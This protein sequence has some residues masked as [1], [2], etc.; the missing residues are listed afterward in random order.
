MARARTVSKD[1]V[2]F[3]PDERIEDE[4]KLLLDEWAEKQSDPITVPVPIEDIIELHL[5]LEFSISDLKTELGH[6][7]VL[8]AIWFGDRRIK[9]DESLDFNQYPRMRGRYFFTLAHEVG[10]WRLHRQ[11]LAEDP[12]ALRLFDKDG[13]PAFVCRSTEKPREEWQA[14]TFASLVLMPKQLVRDAWCDWR[15][16]D[17]PVRIGDLPVCDF[18][19]KI[20]ADQNMAM[21]RF[22]KPMAERFEVSA[23]AMRIRLQKLGLMV[24][25]IEP[26]LF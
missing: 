8:G 13:E 12:N 17:D 21:E 15:G 2:P 23:Q 25:E 18:H 26:K 4:A 14:D 19:G 10:H 5:G 22:C 3:L 24:E 6:S 7:D 9:V 20:E 11:H 1:K 16:T